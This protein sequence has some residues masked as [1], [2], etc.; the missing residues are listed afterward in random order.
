KRTRSRRSKRPAGRSPQTLAHQP[1]AQARED[2]LPR[3]RFGQVYSIPQL[4]SLSRTSDTKSPVIDAIGWFREPPSGCPATRAAIGPR[5]AADD[6]LQLIPLTDR[7]D[8]RLGGV[9]LIPVGTPLF[10]VPV[11]VEQPEAVGVV[12]T[13]RTWLP[14]ARSIQRAAVRRVSLKVSLV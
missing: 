6:L 2:I 5:A 13:D 1:E 3:L 14:Y 4:G 12:G 10:H 8:L 7:I 11:H 9:R